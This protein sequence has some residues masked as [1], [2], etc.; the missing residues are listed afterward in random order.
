MLGFPIPDSLQDL[1]NKIL[2]KEDSLS[3]REESPSSVDYTY[4]EVVYRGVPV[5]VIDRITVVYPSS[6][7][8]EIFSAVRDTDGVLLGSRKSQHYES[9]EAL[10]P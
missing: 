3:V 1:F 7:P 4:R 2:R 10:I 8:T 5:K 9:P 6:K